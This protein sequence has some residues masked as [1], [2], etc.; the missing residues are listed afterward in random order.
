MAG[1]HEAGSSS[2][3]RRK[4]PAVRMRPLRGQPTAPVAEGEENTPM[5]E[6]PV[7]EAP[8]ESWSPGEEEVEE[9]TR[10]MAQE[11]NV[12]EES[13]DLRPREVGPYTL[14]FSIFLHFVYRGVKTA[15]KDA[16]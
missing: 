10:R 13:P 1:E 14:P 2:G 15:L 8:S 16:V 11:Q 12:E 3:G 4:I 5:P 9:H 7:E 6:S